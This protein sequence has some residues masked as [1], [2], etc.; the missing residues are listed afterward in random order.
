MLACRSED[1]PRG[2]S[3]IIMQSLKTLQQNG[4]K[5]KYFKQQ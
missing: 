5:L 2:S 1:M 4:P 3:S